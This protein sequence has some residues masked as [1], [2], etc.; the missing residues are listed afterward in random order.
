MSEPLPSPDD[1]ADDAR[2]SSPLLAADADAALF[3]GR[4]VVRTARSRRDVTDGVVVSHGVIPGVGPMW[5]V[6]Y[7][8]E[9]GPRE[10]VERAALDACFALTTLT[11]T[12]GRSP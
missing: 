8:G 10:E 12:S 6:Q 5:C 2:A 1:G 9:S 3:V 4:R 11:R 7:G